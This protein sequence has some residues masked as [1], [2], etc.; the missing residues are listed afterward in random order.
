MK[1][2]DYYRAKRNE[3]SNLV[4]VL[5]EKGK[6]VKRQTIKL[7]SKLELNTQKQEK[8]KTSQGKLVVQVR[9]MQASSVNLDINYLTNN[10]S[11]SPFYDL[12]ADNINSPINLMCQSK[13][14]QNTGIDWKK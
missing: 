13:V 14:V 10:A 2:V 6:Q 3:L 1:L 12:R 5:Y 7:N 11:W 8:K 4:D 9:Q